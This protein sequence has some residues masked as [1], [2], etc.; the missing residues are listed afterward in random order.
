MHYN[1]VA[2]RLD[3]VYSNS[4]PQQGRELAD[5]RLILFSD[6]HKGQRDDADDFQQCEPTY[7]VALAH[8]WQEG[9]ELG[10]VGDVEE[11]WECWP[12]PVIRAYNGVLT[13]EQRFAEASG[14]SRYLRFVGNHDDLWYNQSQVQRHLGTY[15]AGRPVME[16]LRIL[17]HQHGQPLGELF[18]VHGHQG[19][20]DSDRFARI[21]ALAVRFIWRPI[22]RLLNVKTSTPSNNFELRQEH[23]LAMYRY[24][25]SR[26]GLVLMAGHTHHPVWEGLGLEQA[27]AEAEAEGA[28]P[29]VDPTWLSEQIAGA[30]T[31]PGRKPC[32]FNTGCCSF[33]DGSLTGIELADGEVRLVR[34]QNPAAPARTV[35]FASDLA[36]VL[37]AVA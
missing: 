15:L 14:P 17:V 20:L 22:Q 11:L 35:L 4:S 16:G 10:L 6:L 32:Y 33:S 19:T 5:L 25:E 36:S 24:A 3:E 30:A 34:W 1:D 29:P 26:P 28:A 9:F 2:R 8:Y 31:L 21:S 12:G 27:L 37:A 18:M 23:E 7:L 13:Q